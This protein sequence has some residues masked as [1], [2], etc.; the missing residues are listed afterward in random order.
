M[1]DK[2]GCFGVPLGLTL[3]LRGLTMRAMN[4]NPMTN[5]K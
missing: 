3:P 5:A 2:K 4:A 1:S